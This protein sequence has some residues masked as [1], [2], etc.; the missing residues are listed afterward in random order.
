MTFDRGQPQSTARLFISYRRE[1]T[2][3]YAGRIYDA[4]VARLGAGNV[5]MDI[6]TIPPGADFPDAISTAMSKSTVV[7]ALIGPRWAV[8]RNANGQARLE[9]PQDFVR[10]ELESALRLNTPVIPLLIQGAKMPRADELPKSLSSL[11]RKHAFELSDS[12]WRDDVQNLI[13]E[14]ECKPKQ[15]GIQSDWQ[16]PPTDGR[17]SGQQKP[18]ALWLGAAT[19]IAAVAVVV[20]SLMSQSTS[21]SGGGPS[22]PARPSSP[23][24]YSVP[25]TTVATTPGTASDP[26]E[27]A[28]ARHD[29]AEQIIS[30][31]R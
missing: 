15:G 3:G 22:S 16:R 28:R 18:R 21:G 30:S 31:F 6:D 7:L 14:I 11:T 26:E 25:M 27:V 5:F 12:R 29:A 2:S 20:A 10:L 8:C 1:D 17:D 13:A 19:A 9:D 4:L 23:S 24:N